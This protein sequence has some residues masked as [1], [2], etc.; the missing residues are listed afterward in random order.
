MKWFFIACSFL[1]T[2]DLSA[3][4]LTF[5]TANG[6]V[7]SAI[8]NQPKK[9]SSSKGVLLIHMEK[10]SA[11]D[12]FYLT[13]RLNLAGINSL[14]INLR[15][16]GDSPVQKTK[17]EKADYEAMKKEVQA[18]VNWLAKKGFDEIIVVGA[19]L[20]ANLAL[21]VRVSRGRK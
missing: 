2:A 16:H 9:T 11:K 12:W 18:G 19:V 17:L 13:K 7:V 21:Q 3:A 10:G 20:G 6:D 4:S 15:G 8:H 5:K 14:A 1:I